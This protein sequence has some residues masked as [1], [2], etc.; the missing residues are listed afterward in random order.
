M[1]AI[2]GAMTALFDLALWPFELLGNMVAMIVISGVFGIV[3]LIAFK[4]ISWQKGI[5]SAKDR[6]KGHMIEIRI[7]QDDLVVVGKSV[8]KIL[9]RNFQYVGLNFGP[10]I[11]LAIPFVLVMA[12]FVVRYA[13]DPVPVT[14]V[15]EGMLPGEGTTVQV[16][17][18]EKNRAAAA[19]LQVILPE[20]VKAVS[21]LVR[22]PGSGRAFIEVVATAPGNHELVFEV[23]DGKGGVT[24]ETKILTAGDE[25]ARQ[26]QPYRTLASNW[27]L[28]LSPESCSMLWPAE[29]H[30][31]SASPFASIAIA[32]P[33]RD[34]GWV[35]DGEMG[36]L[37]VL[38]GA[39]MLFGFAA[40]KPLGVQI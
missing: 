12:Q 5:K 36:I 25:P 7:Y 16:A 39:S 20:G 31:T 2:N 40:L 18:K 13:Y 27:Y 17:L 29:P 11:P 8:T 3:A 32:Y 30:F 14:Q 26:M 24:R 4:Y 28:L 34:L 38:I 1:N 19:D 22:S 6:I 35:P 9:W 15:T 10:F 37:L 21:P 33:Y 23:P